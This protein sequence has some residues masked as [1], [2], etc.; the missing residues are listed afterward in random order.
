MN[1]LQRKL[2]KMKACGW[3]DGTEA[4]EWAGQFKGRNQLQQAWDACQRGDWMFWYMAEIGWHDD[5]VYQNIT[6]DCDKLPLSSA[7]LARLATR[8]AWSAARS[9]I[10]RRHIPKVPRRRV[11]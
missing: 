9:D 6:C 3:K 1:A 8:L 11:K 10:I 2:V 7:Q 5:T 4:I